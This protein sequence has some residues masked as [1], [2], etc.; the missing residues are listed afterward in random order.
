MF[1]IFQIVYLCYFP[2]LTINN[3][4]S[5]IVKQNTKFKKIELENPK[6]PKYENVIFII[7]CNFRSESIT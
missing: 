4:F 7:I 5:K 6:N 1:D 3:T 2:N